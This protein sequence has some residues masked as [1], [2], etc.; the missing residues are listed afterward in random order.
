MILAHENRPPGQFIP[1]CVTMISIISKPTDT[2][3]DNSTG[4]V[5]DELRHEHAEFEIID[6]DRVDPF[7]CNRENSL[8]WVCGLRAGRTPIRNI[9]G[10]FDFE[11][12]DQLS[13]NN[14]DMCKQ[15]AYFG[16]SL[17]G[18]YPHA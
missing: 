18:R 1:G 9:T 2:P 5:I 3:F 14:R 6:L 4:M 7:H 13:F 12:C 11:P 17:R 10:T 16:A 15:G 8:I